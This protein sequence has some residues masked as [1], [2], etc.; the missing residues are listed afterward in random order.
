MGLEKENIKKLRG[1]IEKTITDRY[2]SVEDHIRDFQNRQQQAATQLR[3]EVRSL[4]QQNLDLEAMIQG[5][6]EQVRQTAVDEIKGDLTRERVAAFANLNSSIIKIRHQQTQADILA[7]LLEGASFFSPRVA[8]FISRGDNIIGWNAYGFSGAFRNELMRTVLLPKTLDT[9]LRDALEH[10]A[11]MAGSV[12]SNVDNRVI[13]EKFGPPE[14]NRL[15]AVPLVV[16]HKSVAALYTDSGEA[17]GTAINVE[18]LEVLMQVT[19]LTIESLARGVVKDRPPV[20]DTSRVAPTALGSAPRSAPA[21]APR[22]S[23]APAPA[24][25]DTRSTGPQEAAPPRSEPAPAESRPSPIV[26]E[27]ALGTPHAE[28][29]TVGNTTASPAVKEPVFGFKPAATPETP[30]AESRPESAHRPLPEEL[31]PKPSESPFTTA[32]EEPAPSRHAVVTVEEP[33]KEPEARVVP[34][35]KAEPKAGLKVHTKT[36]TL[37]PEDEKIHSEAK[38]CAR[39]VVTEIR[40]YNEQ[41]VLEGRRNKDLYNRL[42]QEIDRGREWYDKRVS[43][44]V[45]SQVDYFHDYLVQI[46]G[47][48]DAATLGAD[49][50]GPK[51]ESP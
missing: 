12:S 24:W 8:L 49:Y 45:R 42:K 9:L 41:K 19:S 23:P 26:A 34:K 44:K 43:S 51:V 2:R 20:R 47:E 13:I 21:P 30:A 17:D 37:A 6:I 29:L 40:M 48:N 5:T 32:K 39:L 14:P 22:K 36:E 33:R 35:P 4:L 10:C 18:A 11:P 1:E 25:N 28:P 15:V 7:A 3:E 38:R 16:N 50:P 27:P 31:F 46:L